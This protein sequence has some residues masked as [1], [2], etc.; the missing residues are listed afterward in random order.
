MEGRGS[1]LWDALH[2]LNQKLYMALCPQ[3][4]N[5]PPP[6]KTNPHDSSNKRV[7]AEL[8]P[9]QDILNARRRTCATQAP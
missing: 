1:I 7:E 8:T 5:N 9:A 2:S 3:Q 4:K 6:K